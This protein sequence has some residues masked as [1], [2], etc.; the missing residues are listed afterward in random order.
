[1][2]SQIPRLVDELVAHMKS[3]SAPAYRTGMQRLADTAQAGGPESLTAT[4]EALAPLLPGLGGDFAMTAVLAGACVEWGASPTALVDVL[5]Q[6]ASEAMM[7][8]EVVPELWAKAARGRPLPEPVSA[9]SPQLVRTL[10]RAA[11]WRRGADKVTMTRI[12]MSWFDMEDWLKALI[13][14][15]ADEGFRAAL[16]SD[17]KAEL[18][19][20]AAA[21]AHRSQPAAWVGALAAV[22]DDEPLIVID[23][24]THRGYALTMSGIGDNGQ[25]HILLAD[26]LV[27]DPQQGLVAGDRPARSWVEAATSGDPYLGPDD[28]AI[29]C[30]RLFDG[31]GTY[32]SPEGVP[33]DI[34]PLDGT[35]VLVLHPPNGNYGMGAGRVFE[36]MTPALRLD[37]IL[38]PAQTRHWLSRLAPAVENDLMAG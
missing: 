3:G 17:V 1:M 38:E 27:G 6:R 30:F 23:P 7:L 29:R 32:I 19:E 12:A 13:T 2:P 36:H 10:T 28:P 21:V 20:R 18:R 14:V 16:S 37:R 31:E 9:S 26:R 22:L 24:R 25:L 8:N 35:R 5:P 15:M 33:A 11:R 4:V 34:K